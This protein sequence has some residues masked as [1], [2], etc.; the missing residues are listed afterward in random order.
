[1]VAPNRHSVRCTVVSVPVSQAHRLGR[2]A[3]ARDLLPWADPYVLQLIRKLQE[4]V[5]LERQERRRL[6]R[7]ELSVAWEIDSPLPDESAWA[8]DIDDDLEIPWSDTSP[9]D[10]WTSPYGDEPEDAPLER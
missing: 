5:R 3:I 7:Q 6:R 9:D 2:G 1:M 10:D 4:E 8:L